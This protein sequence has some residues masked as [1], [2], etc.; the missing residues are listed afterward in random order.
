A[1]IVVTTKNNGHADA[2]NTAAT[3]STTSD[4]VTV[5]S[6]A[7]SL[8][9]IAANG[10]AVATF[11]VTVDEEATVGSSALFAFE[12]TSGNYNT[13]KD[14]T[15]NIG[16]IFEDFETGNFD[17][18]V[19]ELTGN[20]EWS[21]QEDVVYEGTYSAVSGAINDS[22]E[23]VL[24]IEGNVIADGTI[25]FFR[26]VSSEG[27]YDK[28][29]FFIDDEEQEVWS[30]DVDWSQVEYDVTAGEHTFIW[31]Y[32]KDGSQSTGDDCAWVDYIVFPTM[33]L[34]SGPL[35]MNVTAGTTELCLGSSTELHANA[36]GGTGSYTINWSPAFG[37]DDPTSANPVASP[38]ATT[39]YT[40]TVNDGENTLSG[41]IEIVVNPVPETPTITQEGETLVSSATE[42]NQWYNEAGI[43]DGATEQVY[44]PEH[45]GTYYVVV[46]N[47]F[48]CG[49]EASNGIYFGFTGIDNM[50]NRE[51]AIYPN[52]FNNTT[53]IAYYLHNNSPLS[54]NIY[55]SVG[56]Y[57][58]NVV[59]SSELNAGTHKFVVD[60]ANMSEGVYFVV[61][62]TNENMV[63]RKL[64]LVK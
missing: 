32:T 52:P 8:G 38:L 24:S 61:F 45:T 30:G 26:K 51:I 33:E 3:L 28:L 64:V 16:L 36:V 11:T 7:A 35:A 23:S 1:D 59:N 48:N 49:S 6:G 17:A 46:F 42:G 39:T 53:T 57:V 58:M 13:T 20:N 37:L 27:N 9:T 21:V 22:Q 18:F 41:E 60:G 5:T 55:S 62:T 56:E 19:W 29:H 44:T 12:A 2:P 54:I 47:D 43:V 31:K 50:E 40:C 14:F 34:A 25:S 15:L 63:T 4:I 10:E